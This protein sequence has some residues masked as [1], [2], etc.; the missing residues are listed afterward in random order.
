MDLVGCKN[1]SE[2][3]TCEHKK[4]KWELQTKSQQSDIAALVKRYPIITGS[5]W[6]SLAEFPGMQGGL[7]SILN[8]E[9]TGSIIVVYAL[10]LMGRGNILSRLR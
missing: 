6:P 1:S 2:R 9:S 7:L 4:L 3:N 5:T 8:N 10:R